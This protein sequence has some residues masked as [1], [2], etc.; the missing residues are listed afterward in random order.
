[1]FVLGFHKTLVVCIT[2]KEGKHRLDTDYADDMALLDN[3]GVG[4][5]ETTDLL[6]KNSDYA[7]LKINVTKTKCMAVS[8][9]AS[10]RPYTEKDS[11]DITVDGEPVEQVSHFTYLGVI[12]SADGTIDRELS[13]RIQKASGAFNKLNS[14]WYNRNIRTPIKIRIYIAAVLTILLYGSEVWSTTKGQMKRFEVF[15]QRCLRK[16]LRIKWS[17]FVTND[18]VLNRAKI[19]NINIFI[20]AARLRW[21]GHVIRMP[22]DRVPVGPTLLRRRLNN[23]Q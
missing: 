7:G 12:I 19:K 22:E 18:E 20:S 16:I 21:L 8:K 4:L 3:K 15:H 9:S 6:S 2:E 10:Q 23:R 13:V 14:I 11:L 17:H 1:M 5:Q